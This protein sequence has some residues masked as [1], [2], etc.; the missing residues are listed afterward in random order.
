M[1]SIGTSPRAQLIEELRD[2]CDQIANIKED[3]QEL[4][5]VLTDAQFNWRPRPGS[6]SISECLTHLISVDRRSLEVLTPEIERARQAGLVAPGPFRYGLFS[7]T[8]VKN[9]EPPARFKV[10]APKEYLP[11]PDQ[12]KDK[13][14]PEFQATS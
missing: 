3:A 7:R 11:A 9:V 13:V 5:A 10:R 12:P 2:Y 1:A 4:T 6:W 8:F 14:V